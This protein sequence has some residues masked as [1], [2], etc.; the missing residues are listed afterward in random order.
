M[1]RNPVEAVDPIPE[2]PCEMTLWEAEEAA[3][4]L[5]VART[6]RLYAFFY[7]PIALGLRRG[8]LLGLRWKDIEGNVIHVRQSYVKVRGKLM[9][10]TPKTGTLLDL[11][12][13]IPT[14]LRFSSITRLPAKVASAITL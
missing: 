12:P 9:L 7:L 8:G 4:F 13:S 5:N 11:S 14:Y 2:K 3:R 1:T 10:S 6:H